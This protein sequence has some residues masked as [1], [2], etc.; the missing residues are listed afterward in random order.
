LP[1]TLREHPEVILHPG[2]FRAAA[3]ATPFTGKSPEYRKWAGSAAKSLE[4]S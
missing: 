4:I 2:L 3:T 1:A